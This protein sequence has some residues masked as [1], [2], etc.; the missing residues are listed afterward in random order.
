MAKKA[1][2]AFSE[3]PI[4][5][6][7]FSY[8]IIINNLNLFYDSGL[9]L[10][11]VNYVPNG[12]V[13]DEYSVQRG[14]NLIE[15]ID[16]TVSYLNLK[17]KHSMISYS[18]VEDTIEVLINYFE[19]VS[20]NFGL[21]NENI[22]TSTVRPLDV[23]NINLRYYFQYINTTNDEYIC[24]IYKKGYIGDAIEIS[25]RAIIEKGSVKQHLENIRGTGL[26][27]QLD[28][29][30]NI[31]LDD[32]YSENEQ[33]FTVKLYKN[34]IVIFRGFLNP[35]G[36]YQSYVRDTW[37][38]NLDCVDGLGSLSNLSFVDSN[39]FH[40]IGKKS[41][42]EI[43]YS[44][45][46]R[47][48]ILMPINTS[49]NIY[50]QGL[51][52]SE[53]LDI[54]TKTYL[55]TDRFV[56][57]DDNTIM[58]CEEVLKSVLDLF[59]A[60][61]TQEDAEWYI[62]KPN[63]IY[64]N[65]YVSFRKYNTNNVYSG[66]YKKNLNANLGSQIDGYYPHHCNANQKIQ[67]KGAVSSVRINYKYGLVIGLLINS[68]FQHPI[69]NLTYE[70]WNVLSSFNLINEPTSANGLIFRDAPGGITQIAVKSNPFAVT[71]EDLLSLKISSLCTLHT[72]EYGGKYFKMKIQHGMYYLKYTVKNN[73]TPISDAVEL[74]EWVTD[75]NSFYTINIFGDSEIQV[76]LPKL[77]EN[78]N[79]TI[80]IVSTE[81]RLLTGGRTVF[82]EIDLVPTEGAKAE[83]GEFHTVSRTNKVSSNVNEVKTIFNGDNNG[84]I[85][86]GAI[87]KEDTLTPTSNWFRKGKYESSSILRIAAEEELRISQVPTKIFS[88]SVY[89]YLPYL[90]LIS[91]N[92]I[93]GKF[94]PAEYSY[95]TFSNICNIKLL[96]LYSKEI[97]DIL[98]NFTFDFG[99]TV[100]PT[101]R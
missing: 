5:G 10:V 90:S 75:S 13:G 64:E 92:N 29:N 39:G 21:S 28:A 34:S 85:Y 62:Y 16:R 101:I 94:M 60:C 42:L 56:R 41:A 96:E 55:N 78:G 23:E 61:I 63:E 71:T 53:T 72:G 22:Q 36:V 49:I 50:Y 17:Y 82:R 3:Q 81:P 32:L 33:D 91:I 8:Q 73:E 30:L 18:R 89:G 86:L 38:L 69:G 19:Y 88:G 35:E 58:S 12:S 95:D 80:G 79:I 46:K 98:Y 31:T 6:V 1:I 52:P 24:K 67:I 66:I 14:V 15:T 84:A 20:I 27:L 9:D 11:Q 4:P 43:I 93:S 97:S 48:G 100:K 57:R 45:L 7:G 54:L 77:K 37:V 51:T 44:C 76:A 2:I 65:P 83:I 74:A 87:F 99:N 25:G 40:F 47:T 59:Q 70:G 26:S 68:K